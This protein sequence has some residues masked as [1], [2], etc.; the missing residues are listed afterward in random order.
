V[1]PDL[2]RRF[3]VIPRL[4]TGNGNERKRDQF[5]RFIRVVDLNKNNEFENHLKIVVRKMNR[6]GKN[7]I[8]TLFKTFYFTIEKVEGKR[9]KNKYL[10]S[11]QY[12][13][14]GSTYRIVV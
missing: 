8:E 10:V 7:K 5:K 9:I 1:K 14:I 4:R 6:N 12:Y 11:N 13:N 2:L 3:T